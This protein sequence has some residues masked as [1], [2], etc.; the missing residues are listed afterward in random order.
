MHGYIYI[1][2]DTFLHRMDPRPKLLLL[3]AILLLAVAG[4]HPLFELPIVLGAFGG[5]F[6]ARAASALR[7]V[8]VLLVVVSLFS[9]VS[10]SFFAQGT[11]P[12]LGPVEWEAFLFG[13]GT[14]MK[15]VAMIASSVCFLATTKNEAIAAAFI[16]LGVPFSPAF[17]FSTALR[18]VPT[19][20]GAGATI[21]QAQRSR[22]LDVES[23]NVIQRMRKQIPLLIPVFASAI[24]NTNQMAMALES[25]GFGA[26]AKRTYYLALQMRPADWVAFALGLGMIGF[27]IWV[28]FLQQGFGQIPGLLR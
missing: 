8:R 5:V 15:L 28:R 4:S 26:Q 23:G 19:F 7:R 10:W 22:G 1:E 3:V 20:I 14:G 16:R 9:L 24:R 6:A 21:V 27:A 12:F 2:G 13:V 17:A 18:L 25:K 11:T